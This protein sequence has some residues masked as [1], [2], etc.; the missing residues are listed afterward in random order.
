M[1]KPITGHGLTIE[2]LEALCD[3][4]LFKPLNDFVLLEAIWQ[5]FANERAGK[6]L[7]DNEGRSTLAIGDA[8]C[9]VVRDVGPKVGTSLKA[10][11]HVLNVSISGEKIS[12]N[13][14]GGRFICVRAED[15]CGAVDAGSL[16]TFL[17]APS[18]AA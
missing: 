6:L 17:N 12:G 16:Q 5:E 4:G 10:G 1:N 15:L 18:Q 2:T 3:A 13:R 11:D 14:K 9:F 8:L 7:L